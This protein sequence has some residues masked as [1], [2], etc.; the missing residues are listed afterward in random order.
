MKP[1]QEREASRPQ[2]ELTFFPPECHWLQPGSVALS[3]SCR[4]QITDIQNEIPVFWRHPDGSQDGD[5]PLL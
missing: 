4:L 1:L 5:Q 3:C 2:A